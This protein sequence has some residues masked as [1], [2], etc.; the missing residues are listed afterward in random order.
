[1]Q[2]N[3]REHQSAVIDALREGFKQ[4]Y[5]SQLLYA[6][7]GFG[8]TEVAIALMQA[9][10]DKSKKAAILLDRLVLVDQTSLRLSK[11]GLEHGVYQSNH[12]KFDRNQN[13]QVC[14]AQT[15]EARSDFPKVDLLIVDECHISRKQTTEY[16]KANP[17]LKVIG[18]TATPFTKGLGSIYQNVV[19]GATNGWLVDNKW[20]TPLR[21][22]IAKEIDMSGVKKV[23]GEWS[24]EMATKRGMQITGDIVS[25][26][27]QKTHEVFGGP[28]KTIVFCA[29]VAHGADLVQQF[30]ER[31]YNFVSISYKDDDEFKREAIEDFAKP[32]T[33]IHGLIATDILTRG[34]DVSDVMIGVSARPFSKSLS[35]HVQ[36]MGRV[37]RSHDGKDFA[38]WLDHSG[39]Y[40]RFRDDWDNLYIDGVDELDK[41]VEKT[42]KELTPEEKTASKCPKCG[43]LWPTGADTCPSCGHVR[44]RRN[45]VESVSGVLEEL[46]SG[47]KSP[48]EDRQ[49]FYSE[50]LHFATE[51][52]YNPNWAK[53]KYREKFGVWPRNLHEMPTPVTHKTA[54]W[55]RSR[56]I[57]WSKSQNRVQRPP[58]EI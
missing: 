16:I 21:V 15:L 39:N 55:I 11:Y 28:R 30:A 37:M 1:M 9:T 58:N 38:L 6:P 14:S 52:N 17:D 22:Y 41:T 8:K 47:K 35:S 50:L 32:D 46:T 57:A 45:Q 25:E 2:L 33:T 54:S 53:H 48:T 19:C 56:N 23:A 31:G 42:K 49:S 44:E 26:W 12:W 34:F 20:L 36:Q 4:G 5:R 18:L 3:L 24:Q 40:L 27:I 43:H 10:A 51:K 29:G 13:L 7:T